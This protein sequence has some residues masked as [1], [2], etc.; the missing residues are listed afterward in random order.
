[1]REMR[2]QG[3]SVS[4]SEIKE[5]SVWEKYISRETLVLYSKENSLSDTYGNLLL[6]MSI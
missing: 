6:S 2:L 5:S 4:L 1:M 3:K